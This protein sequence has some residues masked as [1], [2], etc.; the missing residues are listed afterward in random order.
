LNAK[1]TMYCSNHFLTTDQY[2]KRVS[3]NNT[4]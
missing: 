1:Q 4:L 3:E 2:L